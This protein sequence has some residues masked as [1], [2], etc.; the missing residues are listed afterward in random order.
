MEWTRYFQLRV[1][2]EG[3]EGSRPYFQADLC[4][5]ASFSLD[6]LNLKAFTH[7]NLTEAELKSMTLAQRKILSR[8]HY[9]KSKEFERIATNFLE[10]IEHERDEVLRFSTRGGGVYLFLVL[11]KERARLGKKKIICQTSEV[12]LPIMNLETKNSPVE[13]RYRPEL[14]SVFDRLPSLWEKSPLMDLF[15]VEDSEER[16]A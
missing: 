10:R 2:K 11:L 5:P 6:E 15:E 13:L 3:P 1:T 14:L 16:A 8:Q 12:P 7:L 4:V 9:F